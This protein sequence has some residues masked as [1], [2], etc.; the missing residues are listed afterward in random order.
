[1]A[2]DLS[3]CDPKGPLSMIMMNTSDDKSFYVTP[4]FKDEE[5]SIKKDMYDKWFLYPENSDGDCKCIFT[6]RT[7]MYDKNIEYFLSTQGNKI[8]LTHTLR[9][10][11]KYHF[12]LRPVGDFYQIQ[13]TASV[14]VVGVNEVQEDEELIIK[15]PI[16]V[17]ETTEFQLSEFID[18]MAE[19]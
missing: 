5:V 12:K 2:Q 15:P 16:T 8:V 11:D 19:S 10:N 6:I 13:T 3:K 1:M 4:L 9:H 17:D 7:Y 14:D 18:C